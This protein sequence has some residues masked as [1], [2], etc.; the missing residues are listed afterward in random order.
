MSDTCP[1]CDPPR[2]STCNKCYYVLSE[3]EIGVGEM[4]FCSQECKDTAVEN[5]EC[6]YCGA[7]Y[8]KTDSFKDHVEQHERE[9]DVLHI[10]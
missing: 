10:E 1:V 9:G 4:H 8:E 7:F 3:Q 6:P 2:C 5:Q